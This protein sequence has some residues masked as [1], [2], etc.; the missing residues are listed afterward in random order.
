MTMDFPDM[1]SLKLAAKVHGF[2]M[3]NLNEPE[4]EYREALAD[5]VFP[6]D[7]IESQEIRTGH[8]WDKFTGPEKTDM[9]L[10]T[11]LKKEEN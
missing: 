9:L 5:Y 7:I 3:P 2:R 1:N 6:R 11:H 10:R 8:G 4:E